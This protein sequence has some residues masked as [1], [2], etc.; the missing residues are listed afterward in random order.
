MTN[1]LF[2]L[3]DV[4]ILIA[5]WITLGGELA[6]IAY[7]TYALAGITLGAISKKTA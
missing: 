6:V 4:A 5:L 3:G 2:E 1:L 7:V